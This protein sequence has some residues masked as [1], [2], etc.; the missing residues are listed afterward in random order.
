MTFDEYWDSDE[1]MKTAHDDEKT[2]ARAAWNAAI[3]AAANICGDDHFATGGV[4]G[5]KI[6][7]LSAK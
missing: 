2:Q 1:R 5:S 7:A 6:V 4:L 3:E